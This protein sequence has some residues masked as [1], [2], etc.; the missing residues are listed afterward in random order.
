MDR[1]RIRP[2][3]PIT[4]TPNDQLLVATAIA[5][6]SRKSLIRLA[7]YNVLPDHVHMLIEAESETEL[8]NHVRRIKGY[9]SQILRRGHGL[10]GT[11]HIWAQKFNRR[12]I[13]DGEAFLRAIQHVMNN[14]LKHLDPWGEGL[15]L[16]WDEKIRPVVETACTRLV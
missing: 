7:A 13:P 16:T 15:I 12:P 4:L 14:H 10:T 6:Q 3:D 2:S 1:Y 9:T 11:H 5:E 8:I